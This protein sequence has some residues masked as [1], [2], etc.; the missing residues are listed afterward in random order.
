MF[1]G[2]SVWPSDEIKGK[3]ENKVQSGKEERMP[4]LGINDGK[5]SHSYMDKRGADQEKIMT[6]IKRISEAY[7]YLLK[8]V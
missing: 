5:E 8:M 6:Q 2:F 4:E 1:S 3:R 7:L